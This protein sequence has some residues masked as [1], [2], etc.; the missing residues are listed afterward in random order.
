MQPL[1]RRLSSSC[2]DA[3]ELIQEAMLRAWI[4]RDKRPEVQDMQAYMN[5]IVRH[6]ARDSVRKI[7]RDRRLVE[8]LRSLSSNFEYSPEPQPDEEAQRQELADLVNRA[9]A[10]LNANNRDAAEH[11]YLKNQSLLQT[12]VA[13]GISPNAVKARLHQARKALRKAL[14][15]IAD[16]YHLIPFFRNHE[17]SVD[18]KKSFIVQPIPGWWFRSR[19]V[20]SY[21]F[22]RDDQVFATGTA[23]TRIESAGQTAKKRDSGQL[24]QVFHVGA[25][26]GKRVRV[27]AKVKTEDLLNRLSFEL[28][29]IP[30]AQMLLS[31][32]L[33]P[34]TGTNGWVDRQYLVE[35][36]AETRFMAIQFG[37]RGPGRFW[38]DRCEMKIE[39]QSASGPVPRFMDS[40]V[41]RDPVLDFKL[42]PEYP[43]GNIPSYRDWSRNKLI[44]WLGAHP[45]DDR[46]ERGVDTEE[47]FGGQPSGYIRGI[48]A[49]VERF[50]VL[51]Q[52]FTRIEPFRGRRVRLTGYMKTRA[53]RPDYDGA[54]LWMRV[55]DW[56]DLLSLDN[57]GDRKVMGDTDWTRYEL[58]LEVPQQAES[59]DFGAMLF[60]N[61]T[62]WIN[63][64]KFEPV[65]DDVPITDKH[66][67]EIVDWPT[68]NLEPTNLELSL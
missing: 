52:R 6:V 48:N 57:M 44:G 7:I 53:N 36:P 67:Y 2:S 8:T 25:L 11:F 22:V 56:D 26:A 42:K 68:P 4:A 14:E 55:D 63:G 15:S 10:T 58:V 46:Y 3:D 60:G 41:N 54:A 9:L 33:E 1:A 49:D 51:Q 31:D 59:I 40:E 39:D 47:S 16:E 29:L 21:N 34:L 20:D 12:A 38:I 23:S 18:L 37:F 13:L 45:F 66:F 19:R 24:F 61:G 32:Y 28:K 35:I 64:L 50:G 17:M 62:A 27:T 5:G 43:N 30:S 65:G